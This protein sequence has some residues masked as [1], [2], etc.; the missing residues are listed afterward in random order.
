MSYQCENA[1]STPVSSNSYYAATRTPPAP[2][3]FRVNPSVELGGLKEIRPHLLLPNFDDFDDCCAGGIETMS[4][5]C[6][7]PRQKLFSHGSN[8]MEHAGAPLIPML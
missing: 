8:F 4:T 5:P 7:L 3:P 6:Q 2:R 1:P